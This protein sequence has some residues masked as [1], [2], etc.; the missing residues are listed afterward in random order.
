MESK[1]YRAKRASDTFD[2]KSEA[3]TVHNISQRIKGTKVIEHRKDE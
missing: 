1:I 3:L 2:T